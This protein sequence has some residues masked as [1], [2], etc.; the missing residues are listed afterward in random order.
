[1]I[2]LHRLSRSSVTALAATS[3]VLDELGPVRLSRH[4]VQLRLLADEAPA[5]DRAAGFTECLAVLEELQSG[6][7]DQVANVLGAPE[8][9]AWSAWCLRRLLGGVSDD[10]A[11]ELD[12]GHLGALGVAVA[13]AAGVDL[14][15]PIPIRGGWVHLPALGRLRVADPDLWTMG[16]LRR[17]GDRIAV[18]WPGGRADRD[19]LGG[20]GWQPIRRIRFGA[21][22]PAEFLLD[23]VS[24][25]RRLYG[26]RPADRLHAYEVALW[27]GLVEDAAQ[28]LRERHPEWMPAVRRV[29]TVL[30]PLAARG[31]DDG[32]SVTARDS[33]GAVALT[34][35]SDGRQLA[36]TLV[37]ELQHN[38]V[39]LLHDIDPLFE[40]GDAGRHYS[41]WR[42]DARP[43]AGVAHGSTAFAGVARFWQRE[44]AVGDRL[45]ELEFALAVRQL[46]AAVGTLTAS[47]EFL[48]SVGRALAAS[49]G[50]L[51][52]AMETDPVDATVGRL[53]ADLAREHEFAWRIR[54][55][56]RSSAGSDQ[57]V[58]HTRLRRLALRWMNAGVETIV[59][60][61]DD[62][63]ADLAL[64][65]G[66][67]PAAARGYARRLAADPGD[68]GALATLLTSLDRTKPYAGDLGDL[69]AA[70]R[71]A[72]AFDRAAI[73]APVIAGNRTA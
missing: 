55:A 31:A 56:T 13:A 19:G 65:S 53:A 40:P 26:Y 66:A 6:V 9:G 43:L 50:D 18:T 51:V 52:E 35:P 28:V 62:D 15:V 38:Y 29:L 30:V 21:D 54:E 14:E 47:A 32:L 27:Q 70:L 23:D 7:P 33:I 16:R 3:P 61:P 41:P 73:L 42:D 36:S 72:D 48:T 17:A 2:G 24:P 59:P 12:L 37:H 11:F 5:V 67:Y 71:G 57:P 45:S 58:V 63:P 69:V 8:T 68:W 49:I 44:R 20:A 64:L 22:E 60:R 10:T 25:Y 1:M 39:N 46:R 4:L 34:V